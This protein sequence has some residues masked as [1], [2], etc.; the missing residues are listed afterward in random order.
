MPRLQ[1]L[2][3]A[4]CFGTTGTAQALGPDAASPL[5]VG[6]MRVAGGAALLLLAVRVAGTDSTVRLGRWPLLVGGLGVAAYQ[7][8]FFAAVRDTGVAVGTVAALAGE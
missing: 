2:L 8:C 7:L 1:V 5:T 6:A 3:A 4:L